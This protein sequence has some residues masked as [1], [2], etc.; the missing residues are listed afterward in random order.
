MSGKRDEAVTKKEPTVSQPIGQLNV[1]E[2]K[3]QQKNQDF[4]FVDSRQANCL[5]II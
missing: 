4:H 2:F 5:A 1:I 3:E